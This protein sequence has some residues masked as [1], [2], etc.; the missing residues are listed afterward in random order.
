MPKEF[1]IFF[2]LIFGASFTYSLVLTVI[3]R[4]SALPLE[5]PVSYSNYDAVPPETYPL[6][7]RQTMRTLSA[8]QS[9]LMTLYLLHTKNKNML[10][11]LSR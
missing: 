8:S 1:G 9:A 10:V 11:A 7:Y 3:L 6:V 5:Y 2:F 4:T